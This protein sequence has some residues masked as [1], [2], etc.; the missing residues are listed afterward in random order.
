MVHSQDELIKL[1]IVASFCFTQN[2]VLLLGRNIG[3]TMLLDGVGA[4]ALPYCMVLVGIVVLVVTGPFA[5]C[6]GQH[7]STTVMAGLTS[8][9]LCVFVAFAVLFYSGIASRY[10]W[11]VF[12]CFFVC[13]EVLVTLLMVTFWQIAMQVFTPTEAKR[14]IG[15]VSMGAAMANIFNGVIVSLV[16]ELSPRGA[17]DILPFQC[18]LLLLQVIPND[19]CAR[20]YLNQPKG[21]QTNGGLRR[22]T[23]KRRSVSKRASKRLSVARMSVAA[24]QPAPWHAHAVTRM[25][26][27]WAFAIV[28]IFSLIEFEYNAVLAASMDVD[29]MAKVTAN[30]ASVA[31]F[32]QTLV[33]LL[34]T[35]MLLQLDGGV[36][37]ALMVTPFAYAIGELAIFTKPSVASVFVAR[38]LDFTFRYTINDS[39]KQIIFGAVPSIYQ[40]E[41]RA[42]VDGTLK[43]MA[44]A[45]VGAMLI[46]LQQVVG[47]H[48]ELLVRP[49]AA[50][51]AIC[52]C[53]LVP[54]NFA[55]SS[56]YEATMKPISTA[57]EDPAEPEEE[58][59]VHTTVHRYSIVETTISPE[60]VDEFEL[61]LEEIEEEEEED[62]ETATEK[63][64]SASGTSINGA[65][66]DSGAA[67]RGAAVPGRALLETEA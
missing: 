22:D 21:E 2:T 11:L 30:L 40:V 23:S 47:S 65:T 50:V 41:T 55:L 61:L 42:F 15:L 17:Y 27:A 62:E 67:Q 33:N 60:Q 18:G 64:K 54:L 58:E 28:V 4:A 52:A 56:V 37:W 7:P 48:V 44:P 53:G 36:C 32:W 46:A 43:K 59:E 19:L 57:A 51:G 8:I 16:V 6:A 9:S 29:G 39:T 63:A 3:A 66:A 5:K 13:E 49:L 26:A 38:S 14:L 35:P 25:L 12:P 34:L 10:P 31:G 20:L 1:G 45:V 24:E